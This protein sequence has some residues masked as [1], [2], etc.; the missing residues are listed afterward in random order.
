M[1]ARHP[2]NRVLS[3]SLSARRIWQP[4]HAVGGTDSGSILLSFSGSVLVH[5]VDPD[6]LIAPFPRVDS[7]DRDRRPRAASASTQ[8]KLCSRLSSR[9]MRSSRLSTSSTRDKTAVAL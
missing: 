4:H 1:A 2:L 9:A 3:A 7:R 8:M 5:G 6:F